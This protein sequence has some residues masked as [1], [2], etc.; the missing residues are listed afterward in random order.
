MEESKEVACRVCAL[1]ASKYTCP[2]CNCRYCSQKCYKLHGAKCV[3]DFHAESLS[4]MMKRETIFSS[5]SFEEEKEKEAKVREMEEMVREYERQ[6]EEDEREMIL[7]EKVDVGGVSGRLLRNEARTEEEEEEEDDEDDEEEDEEEDDADGEYCNLS[8]KLMRAYLREDFEDKDFIS[9]R[10]F[11]A[12]DK[13][14]LERML[15]KGEIRV[16]PW[17]AWWTTGGG[18]EEEQGANGSSSSPHLLLRDDGTAKIIQLDDKNDE[19]NDDET[20]SSFPSPPTDPLPSY[21]SL[22]PKTKNNTDNDKA[23][24][25]ADAPG[26]VAVVTAKQRNAFRESVASA[27]TLYAVIARAFNGDHLCFDAATTYLTHRRKNQRDAEA[28]AADDKEEKE[29]KEDDEEETNDSVNALL[30]LAVSKII[31]AHTLEPSGLFY[32]ASKSGKIAENLESDAYAML[33]NRAKRVLA[34]E[35]L[36]SMFRAAIEESYHHHRGNEEEKETKEDDEEEKA[37]TR[38]AKKQF[39]SNCR[40]MERQLFFAEC[41]A[42]VKDEEFFGCVVAAANAKQS[43]KEEEHLVVAVVKESSS[44][45]SSQSRRKYPKEIQLTTSKECNKIVSNAYAFDSNSEHICFDIR[46]HLG[47]HVFDGD[48]IQVVNIQTKEVKTVLQTVNEAKC[49]VALFHPFDEN[50]LCCIVGPQHPTKEWDYAAHH[51]RGYVVD[52]NDSAQR[53][54]NGKQI[55]RQ[56]SN[57]EARDLISPFTKGA[58]RG[59]THVHAFSP[60]GALVSM[61]YE[62][63]ILA[64]SKD[65]NVSKR[66]ARNIAVTIHEDIVKIDKSRNDRNVSGGFTVC[67]TETTPE[68]KRG[69]DEI[70]RAY[71]DCWMDSRTLS[72]LGDCRDEKGDIL[73]ELFVVELPRDV[74]KLKE[75]DDDDDNG[76]VEEEKEKR[77]LQGTPTSYPKP[78]KSVKQR[79]VTRSSGCQGSVRF[80]PRANPA[81]PNTICI[82]LRD[83][84]DKSDDDDKNATSRESSSSASK[85]SGFQLHLVDATTGAIEKLSSLPNG[86]H[87]NSAFSWSPNGAFI[88]FATSANR[89]ARTFAAGERK[90]QTEY[91]TPPMTTTNANAHANI[92][93]PEC[94]C[95][96]PNGKYV[97]F[98]KTIVEDGVNQIFVLEL[99]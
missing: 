43:R 27:I 83:D 58:L 91:L 56:S 40:K 84:D 2:R 57:L 34:M 22:L 24:A 77:L 39:R 35:D 60:D 48:R 53:E 52:L 69:S 15:R 31:N 11:T 98:V 51:R 87:V 74:E 4:R 71:E 61:T 68:P 30:A 41:F 9:E 85:S 1:N 29:E 67:V 92:I 62:D 8:A 13:K 80:W 55:S 32:D 33:R 65:E 86:E 50:I 44:S 76:G 47:G 17:R 28:A 63:A 54:T 12:S 95:V 23:D 99:D 38:A 10:H 3:E 79:R 16:E 14:R 96:S 89:I 78:P 93:R 21:A 72:F 81:D 45:S 36:R 19:G 59:G 25:S 75:E 64:D 70:S 6:M 46:S 82:L 88:C 37:A 73:T 5:A 94:V 26:A 20:V 90:G 49:G 7:R 18:E 66:N 42:N 97:C